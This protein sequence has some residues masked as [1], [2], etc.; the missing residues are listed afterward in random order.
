[1]VPESR[2]TVS[3]NEPPEQEG[4]TFADIKVGTFFKLSP[5]GMWLWLKVSQDPSRNSLCMADKVIHSTRDGQIV[6]VYSVDIK[7]TPEL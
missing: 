4:T 7:A 5:A 1:M 2:I 6:T 3:Y